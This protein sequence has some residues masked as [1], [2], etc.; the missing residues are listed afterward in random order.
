MFRAYE[1]IDEDALPQLDF[2]EAKKVLIQING[3]GEWSATFILSRGLGR[4]ER[5]PENLKTI[6]PEVHRIYGSGPS[7]ERI[8]AIYGKWVG[9]WL[10]YLW[11]SRLAR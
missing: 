9:D 11:A 2:D 7:I 5:L 10:L 1:K 4:M 3:I 6:M 8:N